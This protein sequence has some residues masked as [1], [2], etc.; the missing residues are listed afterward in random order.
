[1]LSHKVSS[2]VFFVLFVSVGYDLIRRHY[3]LI[4]VQ[5]IIYCVRSAG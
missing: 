5:K 2:I 4:K 1:M 3:L